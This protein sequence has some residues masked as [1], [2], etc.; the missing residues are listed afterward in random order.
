MFLSSPGSNL[1]VLEALIIAHPAAFFL[2][3][4]CSGEVCVASTLLHRHVMYMSLVKLH[5]NTSRCFT[6]NSTSQIA[7]RAFLTGLHLTPLY[8]VN[9]FKIFPKGSVGYRAGPIIARHCLRV[10]DSS[11]CYLTMPPVISWQTIPAPTSYLL[12]YP[13]L[14]RD[15]LSKYPSDLIASSLTTPAI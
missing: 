4:F 9:Y 12:K 1:I 5:P 3:I 14:H 13:H 10:F 2:E 7:H 11:A 6:S 8:Q 15:H